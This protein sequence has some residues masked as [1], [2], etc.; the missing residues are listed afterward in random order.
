MVVHSN[1]AG[2]LR[3]EQTGEYLH[4]SWN[5][6]QRADA[7][8]M[9][10]FDQALLYSRQHNWRR[11]LVNQQRMQPASTE[12]QVWFRTIWLPGAM[13]Q[14][15]RGR[16]AIIVGQDV[17]TRL[18]TVSLMRDATLRVDQFP[19]FAYRLFHY[20]HEAHRWLVEGD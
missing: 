7:L 4:L 16:A 11:I 5:D 20:E 10:L 19:T 6:G 9:D 2:T 3:A 8:I 13:A 1:A 12:V 14:L 17:F 15:E 18:D